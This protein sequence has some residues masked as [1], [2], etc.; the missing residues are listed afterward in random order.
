MLSDKYQQ[1]VYFCGIVGALV[2]IADGIFICNFFSYQLN[3]FLLKLLYVIFSLIFF[4]I[5]G[6]IVGFIFGMISSF[7]RLK[8]IKKILMG[9]FLLLFLFAYIGFT[10][11]AFSY[12][13]S[14]SAYLSIFDLPSKNYEIIRIL[15]TFAIAFFLYLLYEK[16][17]NTTQLKWKNFL[18]ILLGML[19]VE[20]GIWFSHGQKSKTDKINASNI[21]LEKE[22]KQFKDNFKLP[23]GF[24]PPE[25]LLMIIIDTLRADHLGCYGYSRNTSPFIDELSEKGILFENAIVQGTCTSPSIASLYT[26]L[27][28]IDHGI[29]RVSTKLPD[30]LFTLAESYLQNGFVTQSIVANMF[31]SHK[32]NYDQGFMDCFLETFNN[33]AV[34]KHAVKWLEQK[35]EKPFFLYLHF[36]D[37]HA[38]YTPP[39]EFDLFTSDKKKSTKMDIRNIPSPSG[40]K[41]ISKYALADGQYD[42]NY[43]LSKYDGEILYTDDLI[44]KLFNKLA[45]L[46]LTKKTLVILTSD[47]G[48]GFGEHGDYFDHGLLPYD[49]CAKVPFIL[50]YENGHF[51]VKSIKQTIELIDVYPTVHE[52]MKLT[53][54]KNK[55][56]GRSFLPLLFDKNI[57]K[58][59]AFLEAAKKGGLKIEDPVKFSSFI[60]SAIRDENWKLIY[61]PW[62]PKINELYSFNFI[63][64]IYA[65]LRL[66]ININLRPQR[67]RYE[68]YD[69][70]NDPSET[71]NLYKPDLPIAQE[72]TKELNKKID[73]KTRKLILPVPPQKIDKQT[74]NQIK[75]LGYIQ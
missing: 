7:L 15:A 74:R 71:K 38:P 21:L 3:N 20:L 35:R 55:I 23:P 12:N 44:R 18:F 11:N 52:M 16:I 5:V 68:L 40:F 4:A 53:Y 43:Y 6:V 72:L 22:D 8:K 42:L 24:K 13:T 33:D 30:N 37:P 75:A 73:H 26:S 60:S 61:S 36:I 54:E 34:Y 56:K 51:P 9:L 28:S 59:K 67:E 46:K 25:N 57:S 17:L 48:E 65:R 62:L 58:K 45:Q 19:F 47:H 63:A 1:D 31:V 29:Y 50:Y 39:K 69:I 27:Y 10:I 66:I 41:L 64:D 49:D 14:L 32:F 2:G 70:I